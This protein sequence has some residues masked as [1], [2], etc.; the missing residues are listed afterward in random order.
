MLAVLVLLHLIIVVVALAS[1]VHHQAPYIAE[2][3][4]QVRLCEDSSS[5]PA[6]IVDLCSMLD[7]ST[8]THDP[9]SL[10]WPISVDKAKAVWCDEISMEEH[11]MF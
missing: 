7:Y 1:P 4:R 6:T 3:Y 10:V 11:W 5:A 2:V 8:R 9:M